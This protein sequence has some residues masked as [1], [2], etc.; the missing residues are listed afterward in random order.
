MRG[1]ELHEFVGV[2]AFFGREIG[3]DRDHG[4]RDQ[5]KGNTELH[6]T[7]PTPSP[8]P[9]TACFT[10]VG[11]FDDVRR[12]VIFQNQNAFTNI[13]AL[14]AP[15]SSR[16][17]DVWLLCAFLWGNQHSPTTFCDEEIRQSSFRIDLRRSLITAVGLSEA[18][19]LFISG[20]PVE[21]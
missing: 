17:V 11:T 15:W 16:T 20:A 19:S 6:A 4:A 7:R 2:A 8:R 5:P 12:F 14:Q 21:G 9:R 10:G 3:A 13:D 18:V 1:D